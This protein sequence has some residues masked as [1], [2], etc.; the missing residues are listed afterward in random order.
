MTKVTE[1]QQQQGQ[2]YINSES[3]IDCEST[4]P[5]EETMN[6]IILYNRS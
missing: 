3:F 1:Q 6:I 2:K 4:F 5:D